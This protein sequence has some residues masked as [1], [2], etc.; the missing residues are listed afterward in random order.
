[1]K[2]KTEGLTEALDLINWI[3]QGKIL[4]Q[5]LDEYSIKVV[6]RTAPYIAKPPQSTYRRTGRL[7]R[8]WFRRSASK[9][10]VLM[11]NR[12]TYSG[13]VQDK[14]KQAWFHRQHGWHTIQDRADAA[15]NV[16]VFWRSIERQLRQRMRMRNA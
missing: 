8:S 10:R 4:N 6:E 11:G 13:W 16:A 1:M 9:Q 12:A 15:P 7:G 3:A 5:A 14:D 2:I